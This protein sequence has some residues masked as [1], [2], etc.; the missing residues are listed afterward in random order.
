MSTAP[1]KVALPTK[2]AAKPKAKSGSTLT[3]ECIR[4]AKSS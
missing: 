2:G 4:P 3:F 1:P